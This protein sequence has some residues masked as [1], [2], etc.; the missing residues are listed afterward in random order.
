[1]HYV[2]TTILPDEPEPVDLLPE[3]LGPFIFH[4]IE[5]DEV[6]LTAYESE[7]MAVYEWGGDAWVAGR[8][9]DEPRE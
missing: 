7:R 2:T 6:A 1:M 3:N 9:C 8:F 5:Q 4:W